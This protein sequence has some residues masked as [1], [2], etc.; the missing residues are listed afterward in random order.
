[1]TPDQA[2]KHPWILEGLP[3]KVLI[4]HQKLHSI[5]TRELPPSIREQ[6][7]LY[8]AECDE[9]MQAEFRETPCDDGDQTTKQHKRGQRSGSLSIKTNT[10]NATKNASSRGQQPVI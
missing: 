1:M 2:I 9:E 7:Q 5:P 10:T 8:L 6:R 3:P 4:H